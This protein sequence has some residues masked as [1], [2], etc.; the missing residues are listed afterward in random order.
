LKVPAARIGRNG[1][2]AEVALDKYQSMRDFDRTAEPS[3]AT[4]PVRSEW[5]EAGTPRF[6]VQEH[7]ATA[8]HWDFRLERDG[9]LVSWALPRGLPPD[10][11]ADH[12]A[13]MTEDHPLSYIDFEGGIPR[14]E[15]GG[16]KVVVWDSGTYEV[17]KFSEREVMVVLHGHRVS[18]RHVLFKTDAKSWMVHRMDPAADP[19]RQLPPTDAR[20]LEPVVLEGLATGEG[21][22]FS[23]AW[24]GPRVVARRA[25]DRPVGPL[26]APLAARRPRANGPVA[27]L[28]RRLRAPRGRPGPGL[29]W[30]PRRP[31][32]FAPRTD[33][34][35]AGRALRGTWA[36]AR[37][38]S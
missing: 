32:R 7:H 25:P 29:A 15:Y 28:R 3:G 4:D 34:A 10:P 6:V 5:E 24:S 26:G 18:G 37:K 30:G 2:D 13:V 1:K 21:W 11:R 19:S 38:A 23:V 9:V 12:L 17:E 14:G 33:G 36:A 8:L 31:L 16:G 22:R 27:A 35:G 20:P